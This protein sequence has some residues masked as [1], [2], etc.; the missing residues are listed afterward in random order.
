MALYLDV[1][2]NGSDEIISVILTA[3]SGGP[4][5]M[6]IPVPTFVMYGH[7]ARVLSVPVREVSLDGDLRLDAAAMR[8]ALPGAAVCFL[9][10]PNN[11]TSSLWDAGLIGGLIEEF[12]STVFVIDEAYAAY[13]PG[14]SLWGP[15]NPVNQ[16]HMSTLSKVGLAAIRVGYC[17]ADPAL[18]HAMNKVRHPYNVSAT[19][20]AIAETIL[21]RFGDVQDRMIARTL[22]S[23]TRLAARLAQISDAH[24]FP[25][26]GNMVLVRLDPPGRASALCRSLAAHGVLVKDVS[27]ISGLDGCLRISAG[28]VEEHETLARALDALA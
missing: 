15:R 2:V 14:R 18:A 24:V 25:A 6:V 13:S 20:L 19:S 12:P 22:E 28:T 23:R 21:T 26:H 10:R 9:A 5:H 27:K 7:S 16:V 11:P 3:L 4:G 17:I 1:L 8:K